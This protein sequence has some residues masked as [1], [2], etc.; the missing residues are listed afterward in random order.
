MAN[1]AKNVLY[2]LL[3]NTLESCGVWFDEKLELTRGVERANCIASLLSSR[4]LQKT[5]KDKNKTRSFVC[6]RS[7]T[8]QLQGKKNEEPQQ[9]E[10]S[11]ER[12]RQ[13]VVVEHSG[14]PHTHVHVV[15]FSLT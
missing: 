5:L 3:F 1:L 10:I 6:T 2:S 13:S 9:L 12:R 8:T 14:S 4:E 15:C 7:Y 11:R